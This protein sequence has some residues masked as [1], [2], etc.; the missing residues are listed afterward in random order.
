MVRGIKYSKTA[1]RNRSGFYACRKISFCDTQQIRALAPHAKK[2]T[3]FDT[4]E[5]IGEKIVAHVPDFFKIQF[6]SG[7]A[8]NSPMTFVTDRTVPKIRSGFILP[9]NTYFSVKNTWQNPV[10]MIE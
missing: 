1:P 2:L 4:R 9:K 5:S 7:F 6:E 10:V 8:R 3:L